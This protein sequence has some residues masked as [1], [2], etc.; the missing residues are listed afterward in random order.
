MSQEKETILKI[1]GMSCGH[2]KMAVEKALQTVPGV[3][4]A[5]VD[6]AKKE[7]LVTGTANREALVKAVEDAGFDV[8]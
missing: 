1:E 4:S 5:S 7:A 8:V 3:V 6:L 2:C